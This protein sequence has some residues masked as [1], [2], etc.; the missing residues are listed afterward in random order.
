[1]ATL[2]SS[3]LTRARSTAE[4]LSRTTGCEV[5]V[6]PRLR[7]LH[8]GLWQGLT[9]EQAAE[10]FP[11]E[12]TA[13]RDGHDVRRGG[14][15]TYQEAGERAVACLLEHLP[16]VPPGRTLLAVT[17]GGTARAALGV[18]LDLPVASWARL[19][20]LSNCCWSVLVE[21]PRGWRL[22]QHGAGAALPAPA[23]EAERRSL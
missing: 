13:W 18:L 20:A 14:G 19:T 2:L 22:E 6:D 21:H 9:A 23:S 8:L 12:H 11:D 15:E 16:G 5:T 3:D 7:E 17:H 10:R 1:M 4:A